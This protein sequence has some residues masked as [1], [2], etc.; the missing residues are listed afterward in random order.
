MPAKK[1]FLLL[2]AFLSLFF[3]TS[4]AKA[5]DKS[6]EYVANASNVKVKMTFDDKYKNPIDSFL[7]NGFDSTFNYHTSVEFSVDAKYL[8]PGNKIGVLQTQFNTNN[9]SFD[10]NV[11][12]GNNAF[13]KGTSIK[14]KSGKEIGYLKFQPNGKKENIG[15]K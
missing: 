15:L 10:V 12:A 13:A 5:V 11:L 9:D 2:T 4:K 7:F 3:I 14:D 8:K 6:A 1:S